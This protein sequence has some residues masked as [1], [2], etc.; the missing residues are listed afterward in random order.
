VHSFRDVDVPADVAGQL[1]TY[2]EITG[3]LQ[4]LVK[5]AVDSAKTL[6]AFGSAWSLSKCGVTNHDLI[7]TSALTIGFRISQNVLSSDY[8]AANL[9]KLRFLECGASIGLINDYLLGEGLSL[10][11]SGSNNGQSLAG[12][13]STGTHGSAFEFGATQDFVVGLHIVT[14]P[15][16]HVYLQR[17][18]NKVVTQDF[19]DLIGAELREAD[20]TLFNAALVSFGSFGI[21]HGIMIE[22]RERFLLREFRSFEPLDQPLWKAIGGLDFSDLTLPVSADGNPMSVDD[23]Y[24]FEVFFNPNEGTPPNEAI[25]LMMFDDGWDDYVPP[26]WHTGS[27]GISAS[28]LE[29]WVNS[30]PCCPVRST[31]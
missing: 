12:V 20:D 28:G 14:G 31:H 5:D 27:G 17:S 18:S 9:D 1:A 23:L 8:P 7:A 19:A 3:E 22:A 26:V 6:R 21:V 16:K 30:S 2:N 4:A 25:V 29:S 13:V 24:H 10:K 15:T 11:A